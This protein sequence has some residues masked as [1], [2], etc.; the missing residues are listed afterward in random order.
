MAEEGARA[1]QWLAKVAAEETEIGV[2]EHKIIK[3]LFA[4][5]RVYE[6]IKDLKTVGIIHKDEKNRVYDIAEPVGVIAALTPTTNPTSTALF[7]ALIA[8]K[9]RN[10]VI[11]SP[12]PRAVDVPVKQ[13]K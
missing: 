4:T 10:A 7:K 5:K 6:V 2:Y 13:L 1:S 9:S 12:H 3:N 8:I 11:F